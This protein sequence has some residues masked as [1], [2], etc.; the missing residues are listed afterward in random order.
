MADPVGD[1]AAAWV[2][3]TPCGRAALRSALPGTPP[4]GSAPVAAPE[5]PPE[6]PGTSGSPQMRAGARLQQRLGRFGL[7]ILGAWGLVN[8]YHSAPR[9]QAARLTG[10]LERLARR[11]LAET[12]HY[13]LPPPPTTPCAR[14]GPGWQA[15][16]T[17]VRRTRPSAA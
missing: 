9:H 5:A 16:C 3:E 12:S 13:V 11:R 8:G 2:A 14:A 15:C 17:C 6:R 10:Q 4:G 7:M 1:A